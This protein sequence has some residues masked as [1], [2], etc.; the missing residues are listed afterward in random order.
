MINAEECATDDTLYGDDAIDDDGGT[1]ET[2]GFL[3]SGSAQTRPR[4]ARPPVAPRSSLSAHTVRTRC[5]ESLRHKS[6]KRSILERLPDDGQ[7]VSLARR[8]E[9]DLLVADLKAQVSLVH[10]SSIISA[11]LLRA[12]RTIV[13]STGL[14]LGSASYRSCRREDTTRTCEFC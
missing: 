2:E 1:V 4:P 13:A 12:L 8:N 10:A 9:A 6:I 14:G 7:Q 5:W 3:Y 11:A